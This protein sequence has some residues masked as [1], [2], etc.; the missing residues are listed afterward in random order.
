MRK[1]PVIECKTMRASVLAVVDRVSECA[2]GVV[3]CKSV[4]VC[5]TLCGSMDVLML[6]LR[7]GRRKH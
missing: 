5:M 1:L 6:S 3:V 7:S 2:A 4:E